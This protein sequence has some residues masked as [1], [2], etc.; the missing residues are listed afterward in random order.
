MPRITLLTDFGT[1][2][3]Y[4]GA[5]KG[6][7]AS[8]YPGVIIDDV[9]H[10]TP[11]G[12]VADASLTLARYWK[13]YPP[14]TVHLAV[15]DPGV[16]TNRRGLCVEADRRY[17]VAPD[18]GLVSS[19]LREAVTWRAV[20]LSNERYFLPGRSSTFHGRDLFAPIAAHLAQGLHL[21]RLGL[22][23]VDPVLLTEPEPARTDEGMEGEVI[24]VDRFGNLVTNLPA[25][26]LLDVASGREGS[27]RVEL[28][29]REIPVA[30]TYG[31]VNSGSALVLANSDGRVEVAIR[32]GSAQKETGKGPGAKVRVSWAEGSPRGV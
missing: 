28:E 22:P 17:I 16:G 6:V 15:V 31:A 29:G 5:M 11:R 8:L 19:V 2:D 1:A 14:G 9:S 7:I 4:V 12:K 30:P 20:D 32:D 25:D 26:L 21:S 24:D 27:V 18:N 23:V 13:R 10:E 3:G